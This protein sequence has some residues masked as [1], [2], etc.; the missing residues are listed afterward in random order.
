[1]STASDQIWYND[2]ADFLL[3]KSNWAS[4][5]PEKSMSQVQQLNAIFRFAVYFT[6][7]LFVIKRDVKVLWFL[8]IIGFLTM[9]IHEYS[10]STNKAKTELFEALNVT[11]DGKCYKPT[12]HNPFMNVNFTDYI[13]FPNRP[14]ACNVS[15]KK[16][17]SEINELV[18]S[19]TFRDVDDIFSK[20]ASDRMF[21]TMPVT[22]IPNDQVGFAEWLYK[23]PPTC[24]EKGLSCFG[25]RL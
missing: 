20:R 23:S 9:A 18:D 4:I 24:K 10:K 5:I 22:T 7:I 11:D 2:P 19:V 6:I 15:S 21:Y 8:V 1:M 12:Q 13:D 17:K 25:P 14:K 3:N 16:V